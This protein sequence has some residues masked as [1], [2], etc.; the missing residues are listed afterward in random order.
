MLSWAEF[1]V[2]SVGA[3]GEDTAG[4]T[5]AYIKRYHRHHFGG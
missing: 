3:I 4:G 2:P 5:P 1:E